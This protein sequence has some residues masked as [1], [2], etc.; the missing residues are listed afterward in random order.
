LTVQEP[1]PLVIVIVADPL[2]LPVQKPLTVM[3]TGKPELAV[4][5]TLKVEPF[6]ADAGAEVVT[7]IVWLALVAE[8][9]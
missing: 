2:P 3:E 5:A 6:S 4:A 1:V 8:T 9:L 7:V